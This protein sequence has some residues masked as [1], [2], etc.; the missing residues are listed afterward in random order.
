MK[1]LLVT[2][3]SAWMLCMANVNAQITLDRD[4]TP[5][6]GMGD[7]F[8]L[9]QISKTETKY[10]FLDTMNNTFSLYNMDFTPFMENISVP[11]PFISGTTAFFQPVYITRTLFDCDS[12]NIEYA[13]QS[14]TN[15]TKPFRIVRTDGTILF[16]QDSANGVF[17]IGSCLG[18]TDITRPI[19]NT[20][21]GA[22][23][24]LQHYDSV[25]QHILVYSLCDSLPVDAFY[26]SPSN[27]SLVE[28]LPNPA[29]NT[30]NFTFNLP[31]NFNSYEL[32]IFD[33]RGKEI[34]REKLN[35]QK[36]TLDVNNLSSGSY[37]YSLVTKSKAYQAGKFIITR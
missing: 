34:K 7:A 6:G 35:S 3:A 24:F 4:L 27:Q 17:C 5:W 18:L 30:I 15:A 12:S 1:K 23:L 29:S 21:A 2:I 36:Y 33:N 22:K 20:S 10:V 9:A 16:Q 13:Y 32:V 11:E 25:R 14:A 26:F 8:Y 19:R 28:L 31:D 37:N